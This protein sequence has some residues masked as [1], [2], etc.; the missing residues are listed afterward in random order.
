MGFGRHKFDVM[1]L[2]IKKHNPDLIIIEHAMRTFLIFL[3]LRFRGFKVALWGHGSNYTSPESTLAKCLKRWVA[4]RCFFYFVYTEGGKRILIEQGLDKSKIHVMRNTIS[5]P[6]LHAESAD[7]SSL[8]SLKNEFISKYDLVGKKVLIFIGGIDESKRLDFL[9]ASFSKVSVLDPNVILLL[10]GDGPDKMRLMES[11]SSAKVFFLGPTDVQT[12]KILAEIGDCILMP[13][14]VGLIAVDSFQMR[15]P[16]ITT[17]Y[18]YH[19]PEFEY[20]THGQNSLIS[21]N[22]TSS[23]AKTVIDYLHDSNLQMKLRL[24]AADSEQQYRLCDMQEGFV[25]KLRVLF[26]SREF[27]L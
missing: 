15:L 17:N 25:R 24:G 5:N 22:D 12:K 10:F 27:L 19:A 13:G 8:E 18:D 9:L 20:L 23:Y 4:R 14:R 2:Q 21:A 1:N 26:D 11:A 3:Y 7:Q 6:F 16:I